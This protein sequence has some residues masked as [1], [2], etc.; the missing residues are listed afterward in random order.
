MKKKLILRGIFG[1]PIGITIGYLITICISLIHGDG[2]YV[3]CVPQLISLVGNEVYAVAL[4]ALLCGLL[5][6]GF[7]ASSVIWEMEAWS[8][9]KQ[10]VIYFIV[11]C[12]I[13][14]PIAY[15]LYWMEHSL[16]GF[17]SYLGI[18]LLIFAFFW[19][20][21]FVIGTRSVRKMN[22]KIARAKEHENG[23]SQ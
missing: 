2:H 22:E 3:P 9:L 21:Q 14:L 1:F 20:F 17:F 15:F 13:M 12:A 6:A 19:T 5:G 18:F 7:A 8:L 11:T 16:L 23:E 10:T 4:Q